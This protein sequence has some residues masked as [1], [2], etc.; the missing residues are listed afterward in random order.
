MKNIFLLG[1][2]TDVEGHQRV[3][4]R[5]WSLKMEIEVSLVY[6]ETKW[7]S[8]TRIL[9]FFIKELSAKNYVTI[10]KKIGQSSPVKP[11]RTSI[12]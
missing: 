4:E 3:Q 12:F 2:Y 7:R 6:K 10:G 5:S 8:Y 11:L 1:Y 9:H